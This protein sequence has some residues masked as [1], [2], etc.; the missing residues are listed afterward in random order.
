MSIKQKVPSSSH[1]PSQVSQDQQIAAQLRQGRSWAAIWTWGTAS[2]W[3]LRRTPYMQF[4]ATWPSI[5][6]EYLTGGSLMDWI[7]AFVACGGAFYC[8]LYF[9]VRRIS[10]CT[11]DVDILYTHKLRAWK[12]KSNYLEPWSSSPDDSIIAEFLNFLFF[13]LQRW[14]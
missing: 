10:Y 9:Q 3:V 1:R 7:S 5:Y 12:M 2:C 11:L 13:P 4:L 6:D 14:S 8:L